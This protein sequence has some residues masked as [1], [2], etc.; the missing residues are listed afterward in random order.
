MELRLRPPTQAEF[1]EWLPRQQAQYAAGIVASGALPLAA[2]EQKAI[3]DTT[4]RLPDGFR[5]P[6]QLIFRLMAG[7]EP[8]GWLWL[9]VPYSGGGDP[10]MAWVNDI[11]VDQACRGRGYG[12]QAMLLAEREARDHGMTSICLNVHGRNTI[13]RALYD[14][15]GYEVM[16]QQMKKPL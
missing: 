3:R 8:A 2:A 1:D 9:E 10:H 14:S 7:E 6:G 15:L 12:R 16:S 11:E 4:T 13:A 5:T